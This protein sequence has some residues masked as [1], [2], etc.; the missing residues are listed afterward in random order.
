M[1]RSE[2][3]SEPNIPHFASSLH[4]SG[5]A[6]NGSV[7]CSGPWQSAPFRWD[8]FFILFRFWFV[9]MKQG[10]RI[11]DGSAGELANRSSSEQLPSGAKLRSICW[12]CPASDP[13]G[14]IC[15]PSSSIVFR[16]G[17]LGW[18]SRLF[19]GNRR[20]VEEGYKLVSSLLAL[21]SGPQIGPGP[22]R[23]GCQK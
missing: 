8:D 19:L 10:H 11:D 3:A 13:G 12:C 22:G 7:P 15:E 21:G 20:Y 2:N 16:V 1:G 9:K 23:I 4:P 17:M 18:K 5:P 14:G 6:V